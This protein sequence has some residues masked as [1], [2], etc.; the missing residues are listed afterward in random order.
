MPNHCDNDLRITGPSKELKRF[1]E[2]AKETK[3][4]NND[5]NE[6]LL[7][8]DKFIPYPEKFTQQDK[9]ARERDVLRNALCQKLQK[10]GKTEEVANTEALKK[11]PYMKDGYSEGGYFWCCDNWGTK[12]GFYDIELVEENYR[13]GKN[14]KYS[15]LLYNFN[16]AWSPALPLIKKM[17]EMFPLLEFDLRYFEQG[18]GFNGMFLMKEGKVYQDKSGEY[19]GDRGG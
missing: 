14:D 12:W 11:Y 1:K 18:E 16:T 3:D 2:F 6:E 9:K 15:E 4:T 17:G 19:F 5:N 10:E 7:S 13:E 8:A